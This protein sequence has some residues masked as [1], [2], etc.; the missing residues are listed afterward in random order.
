M[1]S[2]PPG[3]DGGPAGMYNMAA[4]AAAAAAIN[5]SDSYSSLPQSQVRKK[6]LNLIGFRSIA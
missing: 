6:L 2:P 4:A 5:G 1:V 3:S